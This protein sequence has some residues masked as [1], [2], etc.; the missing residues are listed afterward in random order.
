MQR[1]LPPTLFFGLAI[2]AA[3]LSALAPVGTVFTS[4]VRWLGLGIV[5]AGLGLSVAGSRHFDAVGT[6][7]KTFDRPDVLVTGGLFAISRNPMYLGFAVALVGWAIALGS[8]I[9][10]AAPLLFLLAADRW[11]I[12]FEE[13]LMQQTFG[14]DYQ[15]YRRRTMRWIGRR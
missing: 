3:V 7:I 6:N 1:I 14:D 13:V 15:I 4:P 10:W 9:G 12:P 8:I 2:T 11:Y 5:V